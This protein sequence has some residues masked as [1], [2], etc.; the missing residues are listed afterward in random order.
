[1]N[2]LKISALRNKSQEAP[3]LLTDIIAPSL[4]PKSERQQN[5]GAELCG[6]GDSQEPE[7]RRVWGSS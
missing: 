2:S 1:M 5:K 7:E 3:S 4:N 6:V